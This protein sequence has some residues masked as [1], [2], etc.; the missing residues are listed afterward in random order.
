MSETNHF[1][2]DG[3]NEAITEA[4]RAGKDVFLI[5]ISEPMWPG[6][7]GSVPRNE[8]RRREGTRFVNAY[9]GIP[10]S[11]H[12]EWQWGWRLFIIDEDPEEIEA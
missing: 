5:E 2:V 1:M 3:I 7:K 12:S 11:I 6:F 9:R 10:I 8:R 4:I